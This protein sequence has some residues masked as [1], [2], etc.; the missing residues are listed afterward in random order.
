MLPESAAAVESAVDPL[1]PAAPDL[2]QAVRPATARA[3]S[4]A[5]ED[6]ILG[7]GSGRGTRAC[8]RLVS[9]TSVMVAGLSSS[10]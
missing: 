4:S 5:R 6:V 10:P 9:G 3:R 1:A 7:R 2:P 8:L